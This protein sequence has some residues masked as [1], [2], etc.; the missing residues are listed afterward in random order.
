LV[1]AAIRLSTLDFQFWI[2]NL[3][4]PESVDLLVIGYG[5]TLR[6]DDS[7]G[8]R[9]AD[10]IE[11]MNLPGVH[12]LTCNLLTPELAE[13]I[14]Q[15][16]RVVFVDAAVDA[17]G[18]IQLRELVPAKSSQIFAHAAEPGT[19]LAMARDLYG[20]APR[21]WCLAI[22]VDN[23]QIG[24]ELSEKAQRGLTLAVEIIR[25]LAE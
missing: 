9:V 12:T 17:E 22:P 23:L 4:I 3:Q 16:S 25:K 15:A 13:T 6:C 2:H 19:L 24:E 5:S 20:R 8:L 11:A 18:E 14:S 10:T 7:V 1:S 21:A